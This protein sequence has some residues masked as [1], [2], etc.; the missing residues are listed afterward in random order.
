MLNIALY[1]MIPGYIGRMVTI[2]ISIVIARHSS[3][4]VDFDRYRLAQLSNGRFQSL[5]ICNSAPTVKMIIGA[6]SHGFL[7]SSSPRFYFILFLY[8]F[9]LPQT[10]FFSYLHSPKLYKVMICELNRG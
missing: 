7:N 3:V 2:E 8:S 6:L 1:R 5:P 9:K 10:H 4:T